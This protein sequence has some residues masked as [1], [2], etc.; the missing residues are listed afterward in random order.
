MFYAHIRQPNCHKGNSGDFTKFAQYSLKDKVMKSITNFFLD[1]AGTKSLLGSLLTG[2]IRVDLLFP[3]PS[4]EKSDEIIGTEIIAQLE[5]LLKE[6]VDRTQVD[7]TNSLPDAL[8]DELCNKGFMNLRDPIDYGGLG[9]SDFNTFRLIEKATEY[10]SAVAL[11]MAI[12]TSIGIGGYLKSIPKGYL[13]DFVLKHIK[14][15]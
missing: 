14:N 5:I 8:L 10:S 6:K 9:L 1:S 13:R 11:V 2:K 4:Q 15:K 12:Q 7:T 3:F